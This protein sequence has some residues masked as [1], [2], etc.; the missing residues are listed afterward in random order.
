MVK[1]GVN[2]D[3]I[4]TLRQARKSTEPDPVYAALISEQAGA[5]QITVHLRE[6]RRHIQERDVLL[7]KQVIK[8]RLNLEMATNEEIIKFAYELCPHEVCI[9]PERREELT[10]EG[11]LNVVKEREILKTV[12]K[13]LKQKGIIVSLFVDPD[14]NQIE[15]SKAVDADAVEIHTGRYADARNE[16]ETLIEL[17]K[18]IDAAKFAKS[19]NLILNAGH[20]L[21]YRNVSPIARIQGMNT[22]NIGYSI[23][24]MAVYVGMYQAVKEMKIL[25][26][27][28]ASVVRNEI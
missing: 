26:E 2:V 20:G 17:N 19:M 11:G 1:L 9:V 28:S 15:A 7:L 3:H 16:E 21:N 18:I 8:T 22:L 10:T 5:D 6:D 4:A 12:I 13:D 27:K 25:I 23:V 24:G 14:K